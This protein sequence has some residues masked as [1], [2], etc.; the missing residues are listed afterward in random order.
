MCSGMELL[1]YESIGRKLGIRCRCRFWSLHSENLIR[2]VLSFYPIRAA[3][4]SHL[5]MI[6]GQAAWLFI[7]RHTLTK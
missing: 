4:Y 6:L 7:E 2:I 3:I 5:L 1:D